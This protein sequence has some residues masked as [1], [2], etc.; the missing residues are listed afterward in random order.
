[1]AESEQVPLLLEQVD[2]STLPPPP[3]YQPGQGCETGSQVESP[4]KPAVVYIPEKAIPLPTYEQSQKF[5]QDGVLEIEEEEPEQVHTP[6]CTSKPPGTCLDFTMFFLLCSFFGLVGFVFSIC[7]AFTLAAESG[8]MAGFGLA[9]IFKL[10]A[11]ETSDTA[12]FYD[13]SCE[14][15]YG[16]TDHTKEICMKRLFYL[17]RM[18]FWCIGLFGIFLFCRGFHRYSSSRKQQVSPSAVDSVDCD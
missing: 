7:L 3:P 1:M 5:E 13:G 8:A 18:L 9:L 17:T 12:K 14:A 11:F 15:Y 16:T 10:L 4:P 6:S 2:E